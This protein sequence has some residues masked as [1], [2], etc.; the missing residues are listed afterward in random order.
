MD[1]VDP[2]R[3]YVNALLSG[4]AEACWTIVK[5]E[6][7]RGTSAEALYVD[8]IQAA[9]YELGKRWERNQVSVST[10]RLA[11]S[12]TE[13]LLNRIFQQVPAA[14]R[15]GRSVVVAVFAPDLHRVGARIVSD[16]LEQQGW[17]TRFI[18]AATPSGHL[19]DALAERLPDLVALSLTNPALCDIF[20]AKLDEL[21]RAHPRMPVL[22]GGQGLS[23]VGPSLAAADPLIE[24]VPSL[25]ELRRLLG[26]KHEGGRLSSV[27]L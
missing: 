5:G 11:T 15:N 22:V 7:A 6:L 12:V 13:R 8:L 1:D 24:Y 2:Y 27:S 14:A 23:A 19:R 17:D 16:W 18:V 20:V 10:E 9:L 21:R 4:D 26:R 25:T 3:S